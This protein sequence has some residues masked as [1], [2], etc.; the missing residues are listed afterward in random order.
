MKNDP[1]ADQHEIVVKKGSGE[2]NRG[3]EVVSLSN[4]DK[5]TFKA[6][7]KQL[8]KEHQIGPPTLI[9]PANMAPI[10]ASSSDSAIHFTWTPVDEL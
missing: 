10:F 3:G 4:F 2:I 8:T 6:D 7:S 5:V 9:D 1:R